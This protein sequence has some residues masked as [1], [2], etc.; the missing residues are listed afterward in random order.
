MADAPVAVLTKGATPGFPRFPAKEWRMP[1]PRKTDPRTRKV[2]VYPADYEKAAQ[3]EWVSG[4]EDLEAVAKLVAS[5]I[6]AV[7]G[8]GAMKTLV[9]IS[10]L[11]P[12]RQKLAWLELEALRSGFQLRPL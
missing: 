5:C 11:I 7:R 2:K 10:E 12:A 3:A 8:F 4:L 6:E 9:T 1:R